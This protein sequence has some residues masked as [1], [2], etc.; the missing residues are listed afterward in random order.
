MS[1]GVSLIPIEPKATSGRKWSCTNCT[2]PTN[3]VPE[4][5]IEICKIINSSFG[6]KEEGR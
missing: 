4:D 2:D 6:S 5:V 3:I 1:D